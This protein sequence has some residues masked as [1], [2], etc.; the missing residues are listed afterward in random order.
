M[1]N[2]MKNDN[3]YSIGTKFK[4]HEYNKYK[5]EK[6]NKRSDKIGNDVSL[7]F[8]LYEYNKI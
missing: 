4:V 3:G 8:E 6:D 5:D 7:K 2:D 1:K